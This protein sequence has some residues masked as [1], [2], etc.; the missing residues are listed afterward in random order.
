MNPPFGID[1]G[2]WIGAGVGIA[3]A[4]VGTIW[5]IAS[6]KGG[7]D[8]WKKGIDDWKGEID[9]T[10]GN[11]KSD[12]KTLMVD[13]GAIKTSLEK[14]TTRNGM[15][16][17]RSPLVPSKKAMEI[18]ED[19]NITSQ[20]D[21]NIPQ[22]QR[23]I[24]KRSK[25]SIYQEIEDPEER[26]IEI[27]P[28]LIHELIK[29]G[30]IDEKKIDEAMNS[31]GKEFSPNIATYYGV[32]LLITAYI[33]EKKG[34]EGFAVR[35]SMIYSQIDAIS[36]K[37]RDEALAS[38]GGNAEK[39]I[40]S[41]ERSI[42]T[43]EEISDEKELAGNMN[44]LALLYEYVGRLDNAEKEFKDAIK[45]NPDYAIAHYNLGILLDDLKRYDEAEKEYRKAIRI[46]PDYADAYY[47]LGIL[48][49]DLKRFEEAEKEYREVIRI[50]PNDGEARNNLGNLLSNLKRFEEAEKEYREVIRINPDYA[51]AHYNLGILLDDLK[52]FE[53]AEKEYRE[54]IRINPDFAAAHNNLGILLDD[55]KRY[56]EAE[57]E[58]GEAIRINPD[59][60]AAHNNLGNLLS[61]L[62]RFEEAER[63]Y[64]KAI[65]LK[66]SLPDKGARAHNNLGN[67]LKDLK[68]YDEA[69][70][71]YREV[72]RINPNYAEAHANLGI[73]F[74]KIEKPEEAKKELKI[75]KE[76]FER[77][78]REEDVKNVEGLLK[79]V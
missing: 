78:G 50:N 4:L 7:L 12:I 79:S 70:R 64:M 13:I 34:R 33:L 60:A 44:K 63:E 40:E 15:L 37:D 41:F 14:D 6:W 9:T 55:L 3:I 20:V 52:R 1:W 29:K 54:V 62:K 25:L 48:L 21:V 71:E 27:T 53:E 47:N 73:L 22:I 56:D 49:K 67:L 72:I 45:I 57:K 74:S 58:Y 18:L 59:F 43:L 42:R 31:L 26:F 5:K 39:A 11:I 16:H 17:H 24:E 28:S 19:L 68:R 35:P 10:L 65:R 76:L 77:Q 38:F 46:N 8:Q 36:A 66:E 75:A 51:K 69:E 23:E 2:I 61:N 32:L 30:K